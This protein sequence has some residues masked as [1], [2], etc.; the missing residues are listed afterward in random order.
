MGVNIRGAAKAPA[1]EKPLF[2]TIDGEE[3]GNTVAPNSKQPPNYVQGH[4]P[5]PLGSPDV[6]AP[7]LMAPSPKSD[8][9]S[10]M[11]EAPKDRPIHV[12]CVIDSLPNKWFYYE[13]M[14]FT[15]PGWHTPGWFIT[16]T[17]WHKLHDAVPK[18][19]REAIGHP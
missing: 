12:A 17:Q 9:W 1:S 19:W 16:G 5:K 7:F 3:T 8:G 4:T 11:S 6:P 13:V 15:P 18:G 10:P 14:W 2:E